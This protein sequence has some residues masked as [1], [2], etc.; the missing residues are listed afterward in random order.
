MGKREGAIATDLVFY[1][2]ISSPEQRL[3]KA[4]MSGLCKF[5]NQAI[6]TS[7]MRYLHISFMH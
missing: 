5:R 2:K 3:L 4:F 6:R 7:P 1:G